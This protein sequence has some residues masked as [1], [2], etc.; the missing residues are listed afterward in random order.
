M[1][2][3]HVMSVGFLLAAA[4][5]LGMVVD[6]AEAKTLAVGFYESGAGYPNGVSSWTNCSDAKF[7][8]G[9]AYGI[10][11]DGNTSVCAAPLTI[12]TSTSTT[13]PSSAVYFKNYVWKGAGSNW[14]MQCDY[15]HSPLRA[16]N[17]PGGGQWG[18][19]I[20]NVKKGSG[21][22]CETYTLV[23]GSVTDAS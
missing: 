8:A 4:V 19:S 15:L 10:T 20:S 3:N 22:L 14:A 23:S 9:D 2:K 1:K 5:P 13:C 18:C 6:R 12:G 11:S 21:S 7:Y 16:W 17:T